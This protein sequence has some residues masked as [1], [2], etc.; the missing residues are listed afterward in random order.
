MCFPQFYTYPFAF[1]CALHNKFRNDIIA[2][3]ILFYD[4]HSIIGICFFNSQ[5]MF[6]HS[7]YTTRNKVLS[8]FYGAVLR[9]KF[10]KPLKNIL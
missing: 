7:L 4:F 5:K 2:I 1:V 3:T 8:N 9:N 6:F 10:G